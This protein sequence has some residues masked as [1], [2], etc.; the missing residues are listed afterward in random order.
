MYY[1]NKKLLDKTLI[2][3]EYN[4]VLNQC[5]LNY[6][7]GIRDKEKADINIMS[8][9]FA[10]KWNKS[11]LKSTSTSLD[12]E[13]WNY[14]PLK[15]KGAR[16]I[17]SFHKLMKDTIQCPICV[18]KT[19]ISNINGISVSG[20]FDYIREVTIDDNTE[21]QLIKFNNIASSKTAQISI[22]ENIELTSMIYAFENIFN[23][24][25][26]STLYIDIPSNRIY[27][28]QKTQNDIEIF[29]NT[30]INV[31]NSIKNNIYLYSPDNKCLKCPFKKQCKD[32]VLKEM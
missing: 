9:V 5:Y 13:R 12:V 24:D 31:Y 29:K 6:I 15:D 4:R 23:C 1:K 7:Q 8:E 26:Y 20:S 22:Y 32:N 19:Y 27:H 28:I 18:F 14:Q 30:I 11:L 16:T 2:V 3:D 25:I 10:K 17:V 21:I